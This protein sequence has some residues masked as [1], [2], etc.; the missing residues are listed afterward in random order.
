[1]FVRR[2]RKSRDFLRSPLRPSTDEVF[3][4][5]AYLTETILDKNTTQSGEPT[6]TSLNRAFHMSSNLFEWYEQPENSLRFKR[7]SSAMDG[8]RRVS[9]PEAVLQG[10][11]IDSQCQ[12]QVRQDGITIGFDWSSLPPDSQI[13]DVGG[14]IG[15][16]S[17]VIAKNY[18]ML[19]TVIQDRP[20]VVRRGEEVCSRYT[21]LIICTTLK[22]NSIGH[23]SFLERWP[24]AK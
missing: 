9:P 10:G 4:G 3:K 16:T 12:K 24:Q 22:S 1:M 6:D 14:G 17:L 13:L 7:F 20:P 11:L 18:P 5:A 21:S 23:P 8:A 2:Q 15:S 19:R